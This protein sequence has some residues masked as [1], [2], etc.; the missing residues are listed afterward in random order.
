MR[1]FTSPQR[2]KRTL[3]EVLCELGPAEMLR[4]SYRAM[5]FPVPL[6]ITRVIA[7]LKKEARSLREG[8]LNDLRASLVAEIE[9]LRDTEEKRKDAERRLAELEGVK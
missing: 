6:D 5:K 3:R 1:S 8:E 2:S 9:Q 4:G 7:K